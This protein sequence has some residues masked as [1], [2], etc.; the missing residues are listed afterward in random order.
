MSKR[1]S[2]AK[3]QRIRDE[4]QTVSTKWQATKWLWQKLWLWPVVG[5][6]ATLLYGCGVGAMYGDQY[7][8][9]AVFDSTA[10]IWLVTKCLIW[11]ETKAHK[12]KNNIRAL[13]LALGVI[14]LVSSLI[15]IRH[16][17]VSAHAAIVNDGTVVS[18]LTALSM[19]CETSFLPIAIAPHEK[20]AILLLRSKPEWFSQF[21]QQEKE[22]YW[23]TKG[24]AKMPKGEPNIIYKCAVANLAGPPV[25][26]VSIPLNVTLGKRTF[27]NEIQ[28]PMLG[29]QSASFYVM[30]QCPVTA[31][32]IIP[33]SATLKELEESTSREVPLRGA[34][35]SSIRRILM[36]FPSFSKWA[37]QPACD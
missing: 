24:Q 22:F 9:A 17:S 26:D 7:S 12:K 8:V 15:W 5:T 21:N 34:P 13:I 32:V 2:S 14:A 25:E 36:F 35:P 30:N 23:P 28:F 31:S 1:G 10:I 27:V 33:D 6:G 11:E 18:H 4:E 19:Q 37:D 3:Q 16:R 20:V 29:S